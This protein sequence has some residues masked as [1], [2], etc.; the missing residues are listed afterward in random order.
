MLP[1]NKAAIQHFADSQPE[2][3]CCVVSLAFVGVNQAVDTEFSL[4]AVT[5]N[6]PCNA[7]IMHAQLLETSVCIGGLLDYDA[8]S[9]ML[10]SDQ[11]GALGLDVQWQE[12]WEPDHFITKHDK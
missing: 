9:S 5:A 7:G 11:I 4:Y 10:D 1:G 8:I 12:P 6:V 3:S 2:L